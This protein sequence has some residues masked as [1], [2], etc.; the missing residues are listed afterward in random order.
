MCTC[1]VRMTGNAFVQC[2][3]IEGTVNQYG[4]IIF[5]VKTFQSRCI[6][7]DNRSINSFG[8]IAKMQMIPKCPIAFKQSSKRISVL[9]LSLSILRYRLASL[10]A[11]C[12]ITSTSNADMPKEN[13]CSPSP[14]GPNS[15]CRENNGQPVCSCVSGFLGVPPACR[16]ECT[17]SSDCPLTEACSNQKCINPCLGA[18]GIRATC[19][20]INHNPICNCGELVG[21]PFI[22]CIPR[23]KKYILVSSSKHQ[24]IN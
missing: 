12:K 1:P 13:P 7:N 6:D 16:P 9:L 18:C 14:C 11:K 3:I 20:V 23:R 10:K 17:I 19:Q 24:S 4:L 2:S 8:S 15:L 21:D 5:T 22:R